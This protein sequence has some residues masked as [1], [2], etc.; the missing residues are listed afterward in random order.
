[1][2]KKT[3]KLCSILCA[4]SLLSG[5]WDQEPLREARLAYSIGFDIT[6]E[7]QL[8][9]TVELVRSS[10]SQQ[11]SFENEI[12][13]ATGRNIRDTSDTLKENV[14]GN[15][16]YF[17]YGVQ[18]LGTKIQKKG[19][20][21]YLDISFRDPTNPTALVKLIS[22]DGETA[23]IL[24]KKKVGNLL[25]GDFL[26]K[27]IKSLEDMSIFPNE[28]LET[29]ATKML[30][31]GKDFTLPSIKLKGKEVVTN[32]IALFNKDKLT[33]L[34]PSRQSVLF[35]LL[36]D[37]MGTSARITQKLTNSDSSNTS[38]YIT[39]DVSNQK[40]KR[41][42]KITTDKKGNVYA[43]I[44]LQLKVIAI[45]SPRDNLYTMDDREKLNK[46]LSKQ[47]TKEA[48]KIINK[49]QKANCDAFGI[50]RHLIAYHPEL[51][52]K[53]NWDKDYAKV[54][55]KPE[56]EVSILYSGVLK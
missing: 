27:K 29:A 16:R 55:F 36:T 3:V 47:L 43:H 34:L 18:L 51:W 48:K 25:I 32:G 11:S 6:E 24:E 38:D 50:G 45:E 54:K 39:I 19:I 10:G 41:N 17:K 42:L 46:E 5:C 44:K 21:P 26:K 37:K 15:I 2:H 40:L 53:K 4:S 33:G 1:M 30:D 12:H 28:T 23:A 49:L 20:L 22:V 9:Q 31:P 14:T 56:V 13:S 52:R 35:V 8:Q 7:N